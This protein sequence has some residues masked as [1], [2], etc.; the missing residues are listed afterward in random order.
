MSEEIQLINATNQKFFKKMLTLYITM[1]AKKL[2]HVSIG[3]GNIGFIHGY[4]VRRLWD[5]GMINVY[6]NTD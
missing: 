2:I 5:A 4:V 6:I 3:I 1:G